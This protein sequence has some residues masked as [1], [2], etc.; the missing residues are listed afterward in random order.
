[1]EKTKNHIAIELGKISITCFAVWVVMLVIPFLRGFS[2]FI[3]LPGLLVGFVGLILSVAALAKHEV[4]HP[5]AIKGLLLNGWVVGF[6]AV[7]IYMYMW[8][9]K[10]LAGQFE[11]SKA[12]SVQSQP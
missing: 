3:F 8:Q 5:T 1:M 12:A 11:M 10:I 7:W 2:F 9:S 4:G 6:V